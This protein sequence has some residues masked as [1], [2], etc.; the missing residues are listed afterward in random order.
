[1]DIGVCLPVKYYTDAARLGY[2]YFEAAG[3]EIAQMDEGTF[4]DF[5]SLVK[6]TGLKVI[7]YNSYCGAGVPIVGGGFSREKAAAYAAKMAERGNRLGIKSIGV[8]SPAARRLPKGYP[9]EKADN[10]AVEFLKATQ[11]EAG[12]YGQEVLFEAVHSHMTDYCNFTA[13]DLEIMKRC[14]DE[15]I[16]LVLDF[17]HMEAM[18]EDIKDIGY[19]MP[20]VRRLHVCRLL[21]DY[22]RMFVTDDDREFL[23]EIRNSVSARGYNGT[24]SLEAD[25]PYF[26][27]YGA[28]SIRV[29]KD[30]FG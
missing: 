9:I 21:K 18:G 28:E 19:V 4:S 7:G 17:Y 30:I 20:Y 14:G 12:K 25:W 8:G 23:T 1:M 2:G 16:G 24:L 6:R 3:T 15:R 5:V 10:E 27:E 29:L 26:E 13:H 22:G 11:A